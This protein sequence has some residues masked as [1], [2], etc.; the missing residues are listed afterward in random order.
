MTEPQL[1]T[2]KRRGFK[3]VLNGDVEDYCRAAPMTFR[4]ERAGVSVR[5]LNTDNGDLL[6]FFSHRTHSQ[7]NLTTPDDIIE[8]LAS[9]VR[10][11]VIPG[12]ASN[13]AK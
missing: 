13:S 8:R 1:L 9:H 12:V 3:Y 11:A 6:A 7:T 4:T 2:R 5:L 10:E